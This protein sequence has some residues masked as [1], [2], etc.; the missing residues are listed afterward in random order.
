MTT[1]RQFLSIAGSSALI[2]LASAPPSFL[3]RAAQAVSRKPGENVLVVVQLSGGND[4]LNTVVPFGNELYRKA[5]P[6]L[7]LPGSQVLKIND[8][9]GFHPSMRGFAD[10]LEQGRLSILQ[11]VGYANPNRSH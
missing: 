9:F 5:R 8:D 11:G 1:R 2:S 6:T 10:L 3:L 7:A 4:G